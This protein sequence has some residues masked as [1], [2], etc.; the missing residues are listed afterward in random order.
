MHEA[1]DQFRA[2]IHSAGLN[3]PDRIEADGKLR[4]F[5]TNGRRG[6]DS[7]WYVLHGDG[8]PAGA[9]GDWRTGLSETWRADIGRALTP[10][11]RAVQQA[12]IEQARRE[13]EEQRERDAREAAA[14]AAAIWRAAQPAPHKH[15]YLRARG[16]RTNGAR[17]YRGDLTIGGMSCD[18]ALIVA[19]RD[20]EDEIQTLEFIAAGGEKRF[21]AGGRTAG[22]Y[23]A[24]GAPG[25]EIVICEGWATG[26]A[27]HEATGHAVRCAMSAGNLRAVAEAMRARAPRARIIIAGDHDAS[28]TG[29]RAAEDAAR[30]VGG[31]VAIPER[32]GADWCDVYRDDGAEAVRRGIEAAGEP[33]PSTTSA[34]DSEHGV[35]TRCAADITA[36]PVRWLWPGRIARG[37]VTLLAGNP[38]LGKSQICASLSAIVSTGGLWPVD[39]ARCE[40]GS[41]LIVSAEDDPEDT[42][43]P[44]LDAA[45]ADLRRV[46]ILD[47]VAERAPDG[48]IRRRGL[49]LTR[50]IE[51]LDRALAE[52]GDVAL[53]VVDPI[54][55]YMGDIDTHRT[56]DVRA[57][58]ARLVDLAARRGAAIVAVSHLRKSVAGDA[59]MQVTGSLAFVA[60]ARAAYIVAR[61]PVDDTRRLLV[62]A[63]NN[64]GDDRT[65]YAYRIE[66]TTVGGITTSRIVWA[67][68]R[69]TL[70][71]DEALAPAQAAEER[72]AVEDATEFLRDLLADRPLSSRQVRAEAEG[73][74]H[75]WAAVRRAQKR[76]GVKVTKAG[77]RDGWEWRL[78]PKVLTPPEDAQGKM[79]NTFG[80]VEHLRRPPGEAE[81][82]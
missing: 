3:P 53:V 26:A 51:R 55:A 58:L 59:M 56:A 65:G 15:P 29:Q 77:M 27:I 73:A 49:V 5:A 19:L 23:A 6:D 40:R 50:D 34:A 39:R 37:K 71:A 78:P 13:A 17:L 69:V 68:E 24:L 79:L 63:K 42:I 82:F 57:A 52:L 38:G 35:L 1:I 20:A 18:G 33:A 10:A 62:Q 14:R 25:D 70:T 30:A 22:A 7:G 64:L 43:R 31:Y 45:G 44:R 12:R 28:G 60:A 8:I 61:D 80:E 21:L 66:P 74:G 16:I 76:L 48:T 75:S 72:S 11:E 2:A 81:A 67:P 4:R 41:V 54:T 36:R 47:A 32:P 9:F 46:H